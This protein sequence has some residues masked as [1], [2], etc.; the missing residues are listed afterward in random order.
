VDIIQKKIGIVGGGQLGKMMILEAK[1]LGFYIVVLDPVADCSAHSIC[2]VHIIAPLDDPKGYKEL[3][4]KVDIITYEWE[5]ID[6]NVLETLENDGHIIYPSVASLK[7]IQNKHTQNNELHTNGILVPKYAMVKNTDEIREF[8]K[9][10]KFGYPLMLKTTT[11]GY[12]GKGVAPIKTED[13]VEDAFR[14]LGSGVKELMVEEFI[15]FQ[16]EISVIACRGIGGDKTVYPVAENTHV[17]AILDTTTVPADISEETS[18]KA[19]EIANQVM[20]VFDGVGTFCTE[21]FL[22]GNGDIYVNE[23]A[24][25]PH[26]SG[27]Y[28]IEGCFANQFE[29]HIR[30]IVGLPF[31]DTSLI[32]PVMMVNLLGESYGPTRLLGLE[33]AYKD[34][35]VHVH[36][37]GKSE[38]KT[39]RKMGHYTVVGKTVDDVVFRAQELRKVIR[40]IGE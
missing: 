17:N 24:P 12:D 27:H 26:N 39:G 35:D 30:A 5:N 8:G 40:V 21:M 13:D 14:E 9:P 11:G 19:K 28:T 31:G 20:S 1:R 18:K 10:E 15:D 25:R 38:S 34:K 37:Y 3:A 7:K 6:A 36:M 22:A 23:V 4:E 29:N 16:K 33:E 2:D 32:A